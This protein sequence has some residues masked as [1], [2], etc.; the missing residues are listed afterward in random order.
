MK[1]LKSKSGKIAVPL[2][3]TVAITSCVVLFVVILCNIGIAAGLVFAVVFGIAIGIFGGE[4]EFRDHVH[5]NY[6]R[7]TAKKTDN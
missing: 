5:E 3:Y 6:N 1:L 4:L 7:H 2:Y